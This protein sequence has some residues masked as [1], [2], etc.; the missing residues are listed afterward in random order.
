MKN[1]CELTVR[2]PSHDICKDTIQHIKTILS[3]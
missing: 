2:S 1:S 3:S